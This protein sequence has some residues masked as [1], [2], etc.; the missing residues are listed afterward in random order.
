MTSISA[1][2]AD[3]DH[4]SSVKIERGRDIGDAGSR[5]DAGIDLETAPDPDSRPDA[6]FRLAADQA[7]RAHADAGSRAHP[8]ADT[9][10]PTAEQPNPDA[11]P[12]KAPALAPARHRQFVVTLLGVY[13]I[14][15]VLL[16][17]VLPLTAGW[18]IWQTTLIVA[19]LMVAIMVFWM[20]PTIQKR[21]G[22]FI[23]RPVKA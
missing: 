20:I 6:A 17:I 8:T 23:M 18:P 12:G 13:P 3:A 2:G 21:F 16:Y 15:T 4:K 7:Q 22:R 9:A 14:I 19:P 5:F 1:A 11:T 10:H